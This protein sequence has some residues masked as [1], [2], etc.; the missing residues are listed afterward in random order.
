MK[1]FEKES[2]QSEEEEKFLSIIEEQLYLPGKEIERRQCE[3]V[4]SVEEQQDLNGLK[5]QK[6]IFI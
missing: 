5:G 3:C 6:K 2:F 1:T 4:E